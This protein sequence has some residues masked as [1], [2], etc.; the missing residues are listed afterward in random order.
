[1]SDNRR[2]V[3]KKIG[4]AGASMATMTGAV[5]TASAGEDWTCSDCDVTLEKSDS[6]D[7]P[8]TWQGDRADIDSKLGL[9][10]F[11]SDYVGE[12]IG[13]LHDFAVSGG[14]AIEWNEPTAPGE[15]FK[16]H[17]YKIQGSEG[18][19]RPNT[20][21]DDHGVIPNGGSETLDGWGGLILE[22]T[23]GT[24]VAGAGYFL[25]VDKKLKEK[26]GP[27]DGFDFDVSNGFAYRDTPGQLSLGWFEC[28]FFHRCQYQS[29][30]Y[31]ADLD[32]EAS[33][34][35]SLNT[36]NNVKFSTTPQ[37]YA[38]STAVEPTSMTASERKSLGLRDVSD[39]PIT[40]VVDGKEYDVKYRSTSSPYD[41]IEVTKST[42]KG[43]EKNKSKAAGKNASE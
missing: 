41:S 39:K 1:M 43:R 4:L 18:E 21:N 13:Y 24:F 40:R 9:H 10:W 15:Y 23:I 38:T 3:L 7:L 29:D 2:S 19:L 36:W 20:S 32:I 35:D 25:A 8:E 27:A 12:D 17:K 16:G 22:Q 31:S 14:G 11:A 42:E 33:L 26:M 28:A 30:Y 34:K 6:F 37:G 5:G